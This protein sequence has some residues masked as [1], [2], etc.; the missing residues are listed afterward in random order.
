MEETIDV[1]Q[2][3]D[4]DSNAATER[5]V[6]VHHYEGIYLPVLWGSPPA[7]RSPLIIGHQNGLFYAIAVSDGRK[8]NVMFNFRPQ[9]QALISG[10]RMCIDTF[11]FDDRV[12]WTQCF[13]T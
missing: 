9:F 13:A 4:V 3:D 2:L 12:V 5:P 1:S 10:T 7:S 8:L 6:H 11:A